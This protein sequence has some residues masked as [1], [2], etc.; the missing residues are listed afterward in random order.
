MSVC[1]HELGVE[2]PT[3]ADNSNPE[4]TTRFVRSCRSVCTA[5]RFV[6]STS[7]SRA[8]SKSGNIS[9]RWSWTKWSG[10][11]VHV[12]EL[13]FE[14]MVDILNTE[15]RCAGVVPFARTYTWQSITPV[16]IAE[17]AFEWVTLPN[18]LWLLQM[19][20]Y[21]AGIWWLVYNL[22]TQCWCRISLKS[23]VVCQSHG[24]V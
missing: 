17:N 24:N 5:A 6:T 3:P 12:F 9:T 15:F 14:H 7:W 22:T 20:T 19:L 23:D 13:A 8:W 18:L 11:G 4:S 1:R 16:P 2:P 21:F 10:S